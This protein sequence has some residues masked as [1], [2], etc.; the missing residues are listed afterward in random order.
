MKVYVKG[1]TKRINLNTRIRKNNGTIE[2]SQT[3]QGNIIKDG[4]RHGKGGRCVGHSILAVEVSNSKR[5]L[6]R[7]KIVAL[8][9]NDLRMWEID[10]LDK[11]ELTEQQ[12]DYIKKELINNTKNIKYIIK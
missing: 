2:F 1:G 9:D 10:L 8:W 12:T 3:L 6:Y 4:G 7:G 5:M 11:K